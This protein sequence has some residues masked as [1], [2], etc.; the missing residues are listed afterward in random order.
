MQG[1]SYVHSLVEFKLHSS[2]LRVELNRPLVLSASIKIIG[3]RPFL[4][5]A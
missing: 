3:A 5:R 2:R 1:P 4:V